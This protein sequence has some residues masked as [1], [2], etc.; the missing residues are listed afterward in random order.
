MSSDSLCFE[1]TIISQDHLKFSAF[2]LFFTIDRGT[3]CLAQKVMRSTIIAFCLSLCFCFSFCCPLSSDPCVHMNTLHRCF[4]G[5]VLEEK[6]TLPKIYRPFIVLSHPNESRGH[7]DGIY[8]VY[9]VYIYIVKWWKERKE[10]INHWYT[11]SIGIHLL[12]SAK[13]SIDQWP[14]GHLP[15]VK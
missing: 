1:N 11:I 5:N 7:K 9:T 8:T 15:E 6:Q 3:E 2:S 14:W 13:S 10:S 12:N 4:V